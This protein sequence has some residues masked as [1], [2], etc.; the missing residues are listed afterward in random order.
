M[1]VSQT[2]ASDIMAVK[3]GYLRAALD[4][5]NKEYGSVQGFFHR[6]LGLTDVD[7][8]TLKQKFVEE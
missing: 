8:R 3:T 1:G 6:G 5:I 4:A 7:I 2:V